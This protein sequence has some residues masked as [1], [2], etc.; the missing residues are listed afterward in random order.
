MDVTELH[1][2]AVGEFAARVDGIGSAGSGAW[3]APTPCTDWDV[4][5]LVNHLT[6]ENRWT[7][8]L[9]GG[10]TIAD[11]GDRFDGDLLGEDPVGAFAASSRE[12]T[13]AATHTDTSQ[14]VHLSFGDVPAGE[15]LYQLAADHL[16]HGWDLAAATD[17]DRRF[18]PEVVA[19][20]ADW[21]ADRE[22]AYR[23]GGVIGPRI[24]SPGDDPQDRLLA[25]F[26]RDPGW[27][28]R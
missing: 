5:T 15:Y 24:S 9:L 11:V 16:I 22:G 1:R 4:R 27:R 8:P 28:P 12:A 10:A 2:R 26:G 19:A 3:S 13:D 18:D 6:Y 21:F 20:V 14:T 23:E 17:G 7:A 25:G